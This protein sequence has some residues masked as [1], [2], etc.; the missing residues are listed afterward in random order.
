MQNQLKD[1]AVLKL[2][3]FVILLQRKQNQPLKNLKK[4]KIH[5]KAVG[6]W[7][8]KFNSVSKLEKLIKFS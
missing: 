2:H 1:G 5:I 3:I 6:I 4:G 7:Y 8:Q